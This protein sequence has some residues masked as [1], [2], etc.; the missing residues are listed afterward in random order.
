M[1]EFDSWEGHEYCQKY[2]VEICSRVHL[3]RILC[4]G[5]RNMSRSVEVVEA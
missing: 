4:S 2:C 5:L 3:P 1:K